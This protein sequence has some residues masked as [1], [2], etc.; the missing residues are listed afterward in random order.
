VRCIA[1]DSII[2]SCVTSDDYSL[3]YFVSVPPIQ[4]SDILV[5]A[6]ILKNISTHFVSKYDIRRVV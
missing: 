6:V 4:L 1:V 5:R 3:A 2:H